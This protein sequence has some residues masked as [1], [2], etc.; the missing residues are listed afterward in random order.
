MDFELAT[1]WRWDE[2]SGLL[3]CDYVWCETGTCQ[4]MVAASTGL[5]V[6]AGEDLAGSVVRYWRARLALGL[7]ADRAVRSVTRQSLPMVCILRS[8]SPSGPTNASPA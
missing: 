1:A 8:C 6:R 7:V 3:H 4:A 2:D 5:T